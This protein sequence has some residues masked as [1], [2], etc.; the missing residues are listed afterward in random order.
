MDYHHLTPKERVLI[1]QLWNNGI[2][3]R[4]LARREA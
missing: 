1:A 3:M 2:S 4:Q